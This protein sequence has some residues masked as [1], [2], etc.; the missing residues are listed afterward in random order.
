[1]KTITIFAAILLVICM[2]GPALGQT[3]VTCLGTESGGPGGSINCGLQLYVYQ[4]N[5]A[6]PETQVYVP[7]HDNNLANYTNICMPPGWTLT[8]IPN[9]PGLQAFFPKTMHGAISPGPGGSCPFLMNWTGPAMAV[10]FE[11]GFDHASPSHDVEWW[12]IAGGITAAWPA[13]VGLGVGPVHGPVESGPDIPTVS[14]FG[15]ILLVLVLV[16]VG[17][18]IV[19][20]RRRTA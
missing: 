6:V 4:V 16:S 10:P 15:M 9:G 17:A 19:V 12:A 3:T 7:T 11:L 8:I 13:P 20:R 18:L 2:S 5:P 1:M 14:T